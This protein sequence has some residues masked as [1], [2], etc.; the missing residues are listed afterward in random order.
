MN[1]YEVQKNKANNTW[2][3]KRRNTCE[4]WLELSAKHIRQYDSCLLVEHDYKTDKTGKF[5]IY[6][7]PYA[8]PNSPKPI[9]TGISQYRAFRHAAGRKEWILALKTNDCWVFVCPENLHFYLD[10]HHFSPTNVLEN[11]PKIPITWQNS[12]AYFKHGFEDSLAFVFH[13]NGED[14]VISPE[15]SSI[16]IKIQKHAKVEPLLPSGYFKGSDNGQEVMYHHGIL[17][18]EYA[19]LEALSEKDFPKAL[20][21]Q[22]GYLGKDADGNILDLYL[23]DKA[24]HLYWIVFNKPVKNLHF[25]NRITIDAVNHHYYDIWQVT[26]ADGEKE[27]FLKVEKDSCFTLSIENTAWNF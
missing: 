8:F 22:Y 12:D 4:P 21:T 6:L 1:L 19:T 27:L 16:Q 14:Y 23:M 11:L 26:Y 5:S 9:L 13:A 7:A 15:D 3:L 25:F 18:G 20:E 24:N 2:L 10:W 17:Y